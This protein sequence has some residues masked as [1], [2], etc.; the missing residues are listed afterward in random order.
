MLKEAVGSIFYIFYFFLFILNESPNNRIP[1]IVIVRI[2]TPTQI[3]NK[4]NN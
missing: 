2:V 1:I 4:L 3:A